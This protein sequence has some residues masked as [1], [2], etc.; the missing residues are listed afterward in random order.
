M[1][2]PLVLPPG[3]LM[4]ALSMIVYSIHMREVDFA[5]RIRMPHAFPTAFVIPLLLLIVA[6]IRGLGKQNRDVI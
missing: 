6:G 4:P 2:E 3:I 1:Q 5:A